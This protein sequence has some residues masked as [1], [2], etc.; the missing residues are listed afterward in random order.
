M[1]DRIA[2]LL[3]IHD[4]ELT[5]LFHHEPIFRHNTNSLPNISS[6]DLFNAPS[7]A[8]WAARLRREEHDDMLDTETSLDPKEAETPENRRRYPILLR[9]AMLSG[10]GASIAECRYLKRLTFDMIAKHESDL[11]FWHR[12]FPEYPGPRAE[13]T[14]TT[15]PTTLATP[16]S[17]MPLWHYSF[18]TLI[19]DI[20]VLELAIGK[21]GSDVSSS[22][23][24]Y[25]ASWISSPDS[26][27]CLL[28]ALLLQNHMVNTSMGSLMAIHTPRVLFAAAV[29]WAAY[30]IY[31]P[32]TASYPSTSASPPNFSHFGN[33]DAASALDMFESLE[34]LELLPEIQAMD[35]ISQLAWSS[36]HSNSNNT[37]NNNSD[38][39]SALPSCPT[40]PTGKQATAALKSILTANTAE[41]KAATLCVL[42]TLLRR[43]GNSGI[44][45]R[46]ADIIQIL[47]A[48][49]AKDDWGSGLID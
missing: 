42:E 48:G 26:K 49:D 37:N 16:F 38:S 39:T 2:L 4:A 43:L 20:N 46:F 3:Y 15:Q 24:E 27:R 45:R 33:R 12:N 23:R 32:S 9:H 11:I 35:S 17:L 28:H 18:I 5:A 25:V 34:Q 10:I 36:A 47:I 13:Q 44:S 22:V 8:V 21:E 1:I 7:A 6:A 14:G 41:M 40:G 30:M 29:C 31:Q 19:A